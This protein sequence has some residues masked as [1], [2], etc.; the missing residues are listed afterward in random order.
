MKILRVFGVFIISIVAF[1]LLLTVTAKVF[2]DNIAKAVLKRVSQEIDAPIDVESVDFNLVRKFPLSTIEF[3]NLWLLDPDTTNLDTIA[4]LKHLYVSVNS[5][6]IINGFYDVKK[7]MVDGL[8]LHYDLDNDSIS[9]ID[10]LLEL[11]PESNEEEDDSDTS[12]VNLHMSLED[13]LLKN[14]KCSYY[15]ASSNTGATVNIPEVFLK[16]NI[17]GNDYTAKSRGNVTITDINYGDFKLD[18]I[19]KAS[20]NFN[21]DYEGDSVQ[22]ERFKFETAGVELVVGGRANIAQN[23]ILDALIEKAE[24]DLGVLSEYLPDAMLDEFGVLSADGVFGFT[25]TVKGEYS[26]TAMP[27]LDADFYFEDGAVKT[28]DYPEVKSLSFAGK[29]SNGALMTNATTYLNLEYFNVETSES[30][31]EI[32]GNVSNID[33]PIYNLYS[34]G[35]VNIA[36]FKSF[37]PKDV[38]KSVSGIMSWE[39]GTQGQMSDEIDDEFIEYAMNN[40][41]AKLALLNVYANVDD[42][43]KVGKLFTS[44][45]YKPGTINLNRFEADIPTYGIEVRKTLADI[46]YK[47]SINDVDNMAIDVNKF[48]IEFDSSYVDMQASLSNLTDPDYIFNGEMKIDLADIVQFVPD[49]L[50]ET[51]SGIFAGKINSAG[52]IHLDSIETQATALAFEK[53]NLEL[54]CEDICVKMTD[55]LMEVSNL[56]VDFIMKPD[57]ILVNNFSGDYKGLDFAIKNTEVVNAYQ[58]VMLNNPDTLKVITHVNIGDV[59]YALFEPFLVTEETEN[60]TTQVENNDTVAAPVNYKMDI[61]GSVAVNSFNLE[62]YVVDT[63]M[64]IKN[65]RVDDMYTKFLVTDSVY[66]ADSLIFN[67]FGGYAQ[68]SARYEMKPDRTVITIRN[69]IDGL[70]FKQVLYDMNNFGQKDLTSENISG[71][72]LS[73]FDAEVVMLGD[74]MPMERVRFK[75]DFTLTDGAIINFE[76]AMQVSK[77]TGMKELDNIQFQS[78]KTSLF[79]LNGAAYMPKTDIISTALDATILGSQ[80]LVNEDYRYH[81]EMHLGD[82]LSGKNSELMKKQEKAAKSEGDEVTRNGL[83]LRMES[84]K[85]MPVFDS[86]NARTNTKNKVFIQNNLLKL[87]FYHQDQNYN[88]GVK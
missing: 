64:T 70:D 40:S 6:R 39:L 46:E 18:Q 73:D 62:N 58:T 63:T 44:L 49:T 87:N 82:V 38:V 32:K 7:I 33:K 12:S 10:F 47:G 84:R 74:S 11:F 1:V 28:T 4:G 29:A 85:A 9:N 41:W 13:L 66:I 80:S 27:R 88:T 20:L 52:Y 16:G 23:I 79:V 72:L 36:E 71:K 55:T 81:I 19:D 83:N 42:T 34:K 48:Y 68:T 37:I 53:T 2:E 31:L 51:M 25:G 67:A 61:K 26:S 69:H 35:N 3:N 14:L 45:N 5:R 15:D 86:K 8:Q 54:N 75:G 65:L 50:V 60:Y 57:S 21:L 77:F 56:D 76:P 22:I 59:D 43:L 78:L 30:E 24:I 17:L